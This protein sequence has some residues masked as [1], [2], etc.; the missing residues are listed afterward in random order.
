MEERVAEAHQQYRREIVPLRPAAV[1][2][3]R[4]SDM[5]RKR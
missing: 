3:A 5:T 1:V 2:L 4:D